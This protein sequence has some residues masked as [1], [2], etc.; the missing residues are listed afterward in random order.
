MGLHLAALPARFLAAL[1]GS[2]LC[3][4][5]RNDYL[6]VH[7]DSGEVSDLAQR[8]RA[9]TRERGVPLAVKT[10]TAL[11]LEM[12]HVPYVPSLP[13][14]V[15][16]WQ[17][18]ASLEPVAILQSWMFYGLWGSNCEEI[19]WWTNWRRDLEGEEVLG[20]IAQR[21]F[22]SAA[23]T[24]LRAWQ[25]CAEAVGHL[26]AIPGYF[27]GPLFLGPAHPLRD[28]QS[29][30][31][32]APMR[33]AFR[34]ASASSLMPRPDQGA[35]MGLSKELRWVRSCTRRRRGRESATSSGSPKYE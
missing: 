10:E 26:P 32:H 2:S 20:A 3:V 8:Q 19:G 22:G 24:I 16:K 1:P 31:E 18:V 13:R 15:N 9:W 17:S 23:Q 6:L 30:C 25:R 12:V 5:V 4:G 34:R 11:G 21:D 7:L 27:R 14:W 33:G 28:V 29:A 35:R